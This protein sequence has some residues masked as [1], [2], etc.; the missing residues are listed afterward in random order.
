M[1][2][3]ILKGLGINDLSKENANKF[4][5]FVIYGRYGTGKTTVLT[6]EN[7]ALVLDINE[8]GTT[9]VSDGAG[10]EIQNYQHLRQIINNLPTVI[11]QL[12]DSGKPI[13]IVVIETAQKLR[14]ITMDDVM[15][16]K[17]KRPTF[18][19][20]GE[21]ASRIV[22]MFRYIKKLQQKFEFHFAITGHETTSDEKDDDG[23]LINAVVT[24]DAQKAIRDAILSESDVV[25]RALVEVTEKDSK[26]EINYILNAEPSTLFVT[27]IRHTPSVTIN[28]KRFID[29]SLSQLVN[30]IRNGN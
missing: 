12:R 27:K 15:K 22:G 6:R 7:D 14:D 3:D 10:V 23:T 30:T 16:G 13:N 8:G 17:S 29:A 26:K 28:D 19:D 2:E 4:Y 18:N 9:V 24:L 25:A 11:Q 5:R 21:A 1:T 20:Y